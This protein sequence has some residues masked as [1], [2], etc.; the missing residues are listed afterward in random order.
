MRDG[1]CIPVPVP[2][3][4]A[5]SVIFSI[6]SG[7]SRESDVTQFDAQGNGFCDCGKTGSGDEIEKPPH[8]GGGEAGMEGGC[9]EVGDEEGCG[10][11]ESAFGA[12]DESDESEGG[13]SEHGEDECGCGDPAGE[14]GEGEAS[15]V[16]HLVENGSGGTGCTLE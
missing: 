9:D 15:E 8:D 3:P 10:K 5:I 4:V 1:I 11:V 2:V 13:W 14:V 16:E 12:A 7:G 6:A